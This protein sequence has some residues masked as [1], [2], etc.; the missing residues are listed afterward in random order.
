[1]SRLVFYRVTLRMVLW[2]P[3]H[4]AANRLAWRYGLEPGWSR[5]DFGCGLHLRKDH[6]TWRLNDWFAARWVPF[7]MA[8][9]RAER[10]E[11][12]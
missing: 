8:V 12:R 1:M 7:W 4:E 9:L 5:G 3:L 11:S 2:R 6:W 10:R